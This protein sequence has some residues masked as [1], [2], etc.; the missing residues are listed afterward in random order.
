M[1]NLY[2]AIV[3][4]IETAIP[5]LRW[6]DLDK[7][8]MNYERP[9]IAFPAALIN[10]T[11]PKCDDLNTKKQLVD[12]II[13][14]RLCFDFTGNTSLSTPKIERDKSLKY[15]DTQEKVY[16][17]FQGFGTAEFNALSRI[18]VFE[19]KR[20]DA[21]KVVGIVFKTDYQDFTAAI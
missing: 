14:I 6:V 1:K 4:K 10:I 3:E 20:P 16:T 15:F 2:Q 8:Q 9:P 7:G 21:Y 13:I 11:L 19:E 17:T 18:N 5:E 12:A